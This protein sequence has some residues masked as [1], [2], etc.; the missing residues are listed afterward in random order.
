MDGFRR[1]QVELLRRVS[2]NIEAIHNSLKKLHEAYEKAHNADSLRA[3]ADIFCHQVKPQ[4]DAIR[5]A[6]D[7][8]EAVVDDQYW[9]LV[10]YRELL[11]IR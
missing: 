2:A 1:M 9:P 8:L 7:D 11:F 4:M 5:E 6:A 3:E 10:K